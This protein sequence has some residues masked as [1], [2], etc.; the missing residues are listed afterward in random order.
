[1]EVHRARQQ[2][3]CAPMS[4]GEHAHKALVRSFERW[5]M[6]TR[7]KAVQQTRT[8]TWTA[9]NASGKLSP[10]GDLLLGPP[11]TGL[12]L[13]RIEVLRVSASPWVASLA[14]LGQGNA[15]VIL[16]SRDGKD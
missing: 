16:P 12:A 9:W 11:Q 2:R 5:R 4:P 8:A 7:P 10:D 3:N 1:M 15:A 14:M 6:T 13:V